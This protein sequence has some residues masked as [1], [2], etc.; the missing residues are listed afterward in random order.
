MYI[1]EDIEMNR[2]VVS[3]FFETAKGF[4]TSNLLHLTSRVGEIEIG[5]VMDGR[6]HLHN[7]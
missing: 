6:N 5:N 4:L 3:D 1:K 7:E 2:Q